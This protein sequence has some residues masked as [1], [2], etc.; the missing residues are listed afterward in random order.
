MK[1]EK[2]KQRKELEM[3]IQAF[4]KTW[5][6]KMDEM[7]IIRLLRKVHPLDRASHARKL[8]ALGEITEQEMKEFTGGKTYFETI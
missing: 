7:D 5:K 8:K 3:D 4:D 2:S 6:G 1:N